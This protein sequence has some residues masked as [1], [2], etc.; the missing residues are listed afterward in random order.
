MIEELEKVLKEEL[1]G[2]SRD[3][4]LKVFANVIAQ[5]IS[6]QRGYESFHMDQEKFTQTLVMIQGESFLGDNKRS[7]KKQES[8]NEAS[9]IISICGKI[10]A[11]KAVIEKV[12]KENMN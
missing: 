5:T 11:D 7:L 1:K 4:V 10:F 8:L 6:I 2:K 12:L 3:Y 9:R